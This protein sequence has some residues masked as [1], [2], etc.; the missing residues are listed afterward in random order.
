MQLCRVK[1]TCE[2]I[3]NKSL[4]GKRTSFHILEIK[5]QVLVVQ[6]DKQMHNEMALTLLAANRGKKW[7]EEAKRDPPKQEY[8]SA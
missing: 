7:N 6:T 3:Q 1:W 8:T 4:S 2:Q 5:V